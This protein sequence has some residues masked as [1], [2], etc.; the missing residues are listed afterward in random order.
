MDVNEDVGHV[1]LTSAEH[2]V[3]ALVALGLSDLEIAAHLN[4]SATA[5]TQRVHRICERTGLRGRRLVVWSKDHS[6][7]CVATV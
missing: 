1:A 4:L 5:F 6:A 3:L 2:E 7:C